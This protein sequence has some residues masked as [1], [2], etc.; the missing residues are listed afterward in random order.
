MSPIR[1]YIDS[2]VLLD[3]YNNYKIGNRF[4]K[5]FS[6]LD[7]PD[8]E[9]A[10]S[11]FV[12]MEVLPKANFVNIPFEKEFYEEYFSNVKFW[13]EDIKPWNNFPLPLRRL[14][15]L[16]GLKNRVS[17]V[18]KIL[19]LAY[20]FQCST[21]TLAA[22]DAI[23]VACAGVLNC[24]ELVTSEKPSKPMHSIKNIPLKVYSIIP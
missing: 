16:P 11:F 23:H 2:S 5:A 20:Q 7:N 10:S 1:T 12:K 15:S 17:E 21:Y 3:G 13:V 6:I 9:Y 8:R 19:D 4:A 22:L 24:D 18:N 14:F